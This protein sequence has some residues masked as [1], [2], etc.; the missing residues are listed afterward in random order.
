MRSTP[1]VEP[2][3]TWGSIAS[4]SPSPTR[5][6]RRFRS[7]TSR[8]R[9]SRICRNANPP[10]TISTE[11]QMAPTRRIVSFMTVVAFSP[12]L[13]PQVLVRRGV[14]VVGDERQAR[15]LHAWPVAIDEGELPDRRDHR[16]LVHELLNPVEGR[17]ALLPVHLARLLAEEP[18]DVPVAPVDVGAAGG[19]ERL[20]SRGRVAEGA[21]AALDEALELLF[22]PPPE[23]GHALD[24]PQLHPDT[25]RVEVVDHGLANVGDRG[26]AKVVPGVEAVGVPGL[27][28]ELLG[29]GAIV[30]VAGRLPVE[31]EAAGN[32]APVNLGKSE[33]VRL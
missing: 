21:A 22:R 17:L 6:A 13:E 27:G 32:D 15:L 30:A 4:L 29:L 20:D 24:R 3:A 33:G 18:V 26:I 12:R 19:D 25:G 1:T 8:S 11:S 2:R 31:L 23:E 28:Q 16:L 10:M 9:S 7:S 5:T 14:G